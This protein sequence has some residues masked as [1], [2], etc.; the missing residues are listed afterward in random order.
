MCL[1]INV[2]Q[3]NKEQLNNVLKNRH[4]KDPMASMP[5]GDYDLKRL[6]NGSASR[7]VK[8]AEDDALNPSSL[9]GSEAASHSS[10]TAD[11]G[12]EEPPAVLLATAGYD[13]TIRFWDVV[14]GSCIGALQHNESVRVSI[15]P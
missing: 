10:A 8:G 12:V 6:N 14:T 11:E 9:S 3:K 4:P 15:H 7:R 13:H 2:N 1:L 5:S